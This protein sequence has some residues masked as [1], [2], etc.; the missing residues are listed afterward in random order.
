M[1]NTT[2]TTILVT[3]ASGF[4]GLHSTLALLK[5]GYKVVGTARTA[6]KAQH[7]QAI[8]AKHHP[9]TQHLRFQIADLNDSSEQWAQYLEGVNGIL[10]LASPFPRVQPKDDT[11]LIN[12]AKAGT[13]HVLEGA[14]QAG[15]N[16]VVLVSSTGAIGYGVKKQATFTEKDWTDANN[17]KDTTPYFRSKTL[18]ERAAWDYA[19]Q[20]PKAPSLVV[21]NPGLILGP[22]LDPEDYGTS[23]GLIL[24][25]MDGS[26]P[27]LPNIGY[28]MVDVRSVA[29]LLCLALEKPEAVG[30]RF[31]ATTGYW[32][33]PELSAALAQ[34]F[35]DRRFPRRI[36]PNFLLRLF[37]KLDA[38]T[39]PVLLE[40]GAERRFDASHTVQ[41]LG[42]S[43]IPL[44]T[45]AKDMADSLI[46]LGFVS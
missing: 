1:N 15:V 36:L 18:A 21:V 24:K 41:R 3:G 39:A 42:W 4:L 16:R 12:T 33:V 7:A 5:R 37:A 46:E 2:D 35:P 26:M 45:A 40:L 8:I 31:V 10:H 44:K 22:I 13:L 17:R 38:Q 27:A 29:D 11:T 25:L 23:A 9:D 6:A 14:T 43:S 30:Q 32:S 20:N 34:Q 28:G 19:N